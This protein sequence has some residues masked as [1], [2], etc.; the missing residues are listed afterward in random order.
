MMHHTPLF[1]N[2]VTLSPVVFL[3]SLNLLALVLFALLLLALESGASTLA[4]TTIQNP[5]LLPLYQILTIH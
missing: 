3:T 1:G 4:N 5:F 2:T